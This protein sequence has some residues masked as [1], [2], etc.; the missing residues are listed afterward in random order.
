MSQIDLT[1]I[2]G[3]RAS[4]QART[5][6]SEIPFTPM[7]ETSP[8]QK[9]TFTRQIYPPYLYKLPG[10]RSTDFSADNYNTLLPAV[11]GQ[12]VVPVRFAV[13]GQNKAYIQIF[14]LYIRSPSAATDITFILRVNDGPVPGYT[15][16]MIP[17]SANIIFLPY[18]DVQ[19]E[20][21]PGDEIS[22]QVVNNAATGPWTIGALI[23]GWYHTETDEQ[24]FWGD[25]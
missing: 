6:Q 14:A 15:K 11:A 7:A 8:S 10:G 18:N 19:V 22:V 24:A 9:A 21:A 2:L 25:L 20:T 1:K 5:R 13:P 3:R 12:A 17:G 16:R 23:S 4:A